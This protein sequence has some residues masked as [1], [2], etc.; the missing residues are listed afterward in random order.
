MDSPQS[1]PT[2]GKLYLATTIV[3]SLL[4][5]TTSLDPYNLAFTL[6][7]TIF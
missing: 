2:L 7:Q 4:V 1:I 6:K 5:F 3:L